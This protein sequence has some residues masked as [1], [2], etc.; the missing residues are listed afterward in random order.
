MNN[1]PICG[2]WVRV[3]VLAACFVLLA[4]CDFDPGM[5]DPYRTYT[6][7]PTSTQTATGT[8]TAELIQMDKV[9][10]PTPAALCTVTVSK[11]LNFRSGPGT[12]YPVIAWLQ[13]GDVLEVTQQGNGWAN[14]TTLDGRTGWVNQS[15]CK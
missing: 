7:T 9:N 3:L 4:G 8:A 1:K 6:L 10:T 11:S 14:V 13:P 12:A 2:A 15:Y 5:F